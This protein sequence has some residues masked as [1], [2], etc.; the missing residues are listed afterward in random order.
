[1]WHCSGG[2]VGGGGRG[3]QD[4]QLCQC[5]MMPTADLS[6]HHDHSDLRASG[7]TTKSSGAPWGCGPV[8]PGTN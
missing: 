4:M 8:P 1:M 5:T 6:K 3:N 7:E 2:G